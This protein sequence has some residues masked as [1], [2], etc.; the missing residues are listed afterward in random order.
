MLFDTHTH[1]TFS[2]DSLMTIAEAQQAAGRHN[3]GI[4]ITEHLDLAYPEPELFTFNI[5]HYFTAYGPHRSDKLLLGL[6]LGMSDDCVETNR[7]IVAAYPFDFVIGSIH[8]IE[9]MDICSELFCETWTKKELYQQYFK[10]MLTCLKQYD[11][12]DSL[13]HIDFIC[14]YAQ[15]DDPELYY[16]DFQTEIDL[17]LSQLAEA[18][19]AIEINTRRLGLSGTKEALLP[20]YDRF[21]ELGGKYVTIGSDAHKPQ[22]IGRDLS[23]GFE[24]AETCGLTPVYYQKRKPIKLTR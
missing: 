21:R 9:N 4:I 10:A 2:S 17:V 3:L 15:F 20:I 13:G 14:R 23:I 19:Q 8:V 22:N 6:E 1:T 7:Q 11:F 24:I 18:G 12:I 5:E 16:F